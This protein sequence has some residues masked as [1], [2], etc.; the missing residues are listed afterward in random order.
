MILYQMAQRCHILYEIYSFSPSPAVQNSQKAQ[1]Y[2]EKAVYIYKLTLESPDHTTYADKAWKD[3]DVL[4]KGGR[5][6][7]FD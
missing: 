1:E 2:R 3:M 7:T 5:I 6:Y 4:Q